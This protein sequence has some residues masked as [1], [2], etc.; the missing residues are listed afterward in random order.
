MSVNAFATLLLMYGFVMCGA[1]SVLYWAF[2]DN[3]NLSGRLFL[4]SEALRIPTIVT[5]S[6]VHIY[7]DLKTGLAYFVTNGFFLASEVTFV[8]SLYALPRNESSRLYPKI[9]IGVVLLAASF[10]II[11]LHNNFWP[12]PLYTITMAI[13]SLAAI[14]VSLRVADDRLRQAPFWKIL[15]YIETTFFVFAIFRVVVQFIGTPLTPMQGGA[16]NLILL[17]VWTALLI[18]RY[19]SYQSLWMT[20]SSPDAK[21]NRFNKDLLASLRER[22]V[23]LQQLVASNRR[24]GVS[25][26]ASSLAHQLSQPLTGAALQAEAVKQ[27][28]IHRPDEGNVLRGVEKVAGILGHLS[29]VVRNLR[30]LF[31]SQEDRLEKIALEKLCGDVIKIVDFSEKSSG[32]KVQTFGHI[33]S[34]IFGNPIQIQQVIFNLLDNTIHASRNS[35]I[36]TVDIIFE[37]RE[38]IA[39]LTVRDHGEGFPPEVLEDLFVLYRTTKNDGVGIGLWLCK[40]ILE[41]HKG[42]ISAFNHPDGGAS[43]RVEIPVVEPAS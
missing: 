36:K 33:R 22:N 21:E 37:E 5:I 31:G 23:L 34:A 11:R 27:Q 24:I 42:K 17:S 4:L 9:L 18:F 7:P 20:W 28:L 41:K 8:F 30:S 19:I 39:S 2:K 10:E 12:V 3:F 40:Q 26:L 38:G 1:M 13:I 35:Q 6:I 25:A 43:V 14:L 16:H 15:R 32:I 29:D